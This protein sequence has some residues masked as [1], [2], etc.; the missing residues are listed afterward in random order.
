MLPRGPEPSDDDSR[1]GGA[2]A[3]GE[4]GALSPAGL[5]RGGSPGAFSV[6]PDDSTAPGSVDRGHRG[7]QSQSQSLSQ[8]L[9]G[10]P[11][12]PGPGLN[13]SQSLQ[14]SPSAAKSSVAMEKDVPVLP[15]SPR[16]A[17][18]RSWHDAIHD[19]L[20]IGPGARSEDVQKQSRLALL[21]PQN[22]KESRLALKKAAERRAR[23]LAVLLLPE[24]DLC[25]PEELLQDDTAALDTSMRDRCLRRV[26]K[27]TSRRLLRRGLECWK[28]QLEH[29]L[30]V[31]R[32]LM[33]RVRRL[34][35]PSTTSQPYSLPIHY[36]L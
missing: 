29:L 24:H 10:S 2:G 4:A 9:A 7:S 18:F 15:P 35:S 23:M 6:G 5:M 30:S 28:G 21:F 25:R 16:G 12:S 19:P 22:P 20:E 13:H 17:A 14:A 26:V 34:F 32:Y 36:L 27:R 1:S 8:I 11:E 33:V 3:A 31:K